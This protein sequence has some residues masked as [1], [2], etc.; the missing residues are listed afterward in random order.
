MEKETL[1]HKLDAALIE[2]DDLKTTNVILVETVAELQR[3]EKANLGAQADLRRDLEETQVVL[4]ET[5]NR[6]PG[7]EAR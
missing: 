7:R 6:L 3:R 2:V 1:E 5:T 4:K